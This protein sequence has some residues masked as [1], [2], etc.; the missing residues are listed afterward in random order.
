MER[1]E[2]PVVSLNNYRGLRAFRDCVPKL[3]QPGPFDPVPLS[4]IAEGFR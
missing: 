3:L 4:A 2:V 1:M